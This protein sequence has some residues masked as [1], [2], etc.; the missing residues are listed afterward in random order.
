MLKQTVALFLT[1]R[2]LLSIFAILAPLFINLNVKSWLGL[3][4][5]RTLPYSLWVWANFDGVNYLSIA[6]YGYHYPNFAYFPLLPF[7][8]FL[9]QKVLTL[10]FLVVG[11]VVTNLA[12]FL[13][14]LV[15]TK[16]ILLD[17]DK[18][19]SFRTLFF[20]LIFPVSF[21]YGAVYTESLYLLTATLSFYY[22]RKTNWLLCGVFGFLAGLTRLVGIALLP[23]LLFEWY[24]QNRKNNKD[25]TEL[26]KK[27]LKQRAYLIFLV[28]LGIIVYSL[29][30]KI[31]HGDF[32]LFQKSM[33]A[34]NQSNFVFPSQVLWRYLKILVLAPK[35]FV[36]FI[37]L[38][39]LFSTLV[40]FA[41]SIYVLKKIR[42]SYGIFMIISLIIPT[43][44]GTFQSM[45]R[46][47]LHLFPAFLAIA[48]LTKNSKWR[49]GIA[50]I[51]FL[52]LQFLFVALFTRGYFIA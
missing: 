12:L 4:H 48:L 45:P 51:I 44:T 46:Y 11:L 15:V 3:E 22:A 31:D 33:S 52:L 43:F 40:Y 35:N 38:L 5:A 19:V 24:W 39:E 47:I 37:A 10:P 21:F 6:R 34:W 17:F 42:L 20:L 9:I 36:Y 28:P 30:L 26:L 25:S 8:I 23:A 16:I 50:T 2:I 1:W 14:L 41:I 7:L 27:F 32:L 18:D 49:F 13:S 29:Y